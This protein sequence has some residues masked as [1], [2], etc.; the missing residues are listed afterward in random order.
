[1]KKNQ[2]REGYFTG[3][4]CLKLL[5]LGATLS[6]AEANPTIFEA[7][8]MSLSSFIVRDSGFT[9]SQQYIQIRGAAGTASTVYNGADI[10]ANIA[11]TYFD[12]SDGV[13]E[14]TL[15]LNGTEIAAWSADQI[16]EGAAVTLGN[17][18]T[19][20]IPRVALQNGDTLSLTVTRDAG[21]YGRVDSISISE[22]VEAESL[23]LSG[24]NPSTVAVASG[25]SVI[26]TGAEGTAIFS[27]TGPSGYYAIDT[28]YFDE[29]DGESVYS[30]A[31]DGVR[32]DSW[33]ANKNLGSAAPTVEAL[34]SHKTDWIYLESGSVVGLTGTRSNGEFGRVDYLEISP[35][36]SYIE[37]CQASHFLSHASMGGSRQE[38]HALAKRISEIGH[39]E[40][41]EEWID[42]QFALPRGENLLDLAL[43]HQ[44]YYAID[45]LESVNI[46]NFEYAWWDQATT[47]EEQ[48]RHRT[49]F[50]LSQIFVTSS[51][52]WGNLERH[53]IWRSY[54][55]YYDKL[56]NNAFTSHRDIL[57]DIT[58]DPFMGV[59][60]TYA[61]NSK[62][63]EE[64]D[65][66]PDENYA[67]EV[68]QLF[69]CGVYSLNQ[70]GNYQFDSNGNLIENYDNDDIREMAKVFT[71]LSLSNADGS[72]P[73]F[74]APP[75][76]R[77]GSYENEMVMVEAYHDVSEKVLLT[78]E[79]LTA[80]SSGDA[81][82]SSALDALAYHPS[83]APYLSREL[84]K[85]FTSSNPSSAYVARVSQSWRGEGQ[86]GGDGSVGNMKNVLK[87][88]LL[89]PEVREV[90]EFSGIANSANISSDNVT[91]ASSDSLSGRIKEPI[92]QWTQ[93]YRYLEPTTTAASGM[94]L[95]PPR[96][97]KAASDMTP[98]FGQVPMRA[99][100]VFNYYDT[101]HSPGSGPIAAAK[102]AFDIEFVSPET[103]TLSDHVIHDFEECLAMMEDTRT[104]SY[105]NYIQENAY[106]EFTWLQRMIEMDIPLEQFV[107]DVNRELCHGQMSKEARDVL[108]SS[109]ES[110]TANKQEQFAQALTL[111]FSSPYY[112]LSF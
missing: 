88:I 70:D 23:Q 63:D 1:M 97:K 73:N 42:A 71:G 68:M 100:S 8:S 35:S 108:V 77:S 43:Y 17:L 64:L 80:G 87:A 107:R 36:Q 109:V 26:L 25:G 61:H 111:I 52:Y 19:A 76:T 7:E 62:G 92:L 51:V 105:L 84:I 106:V 21:E 30:L 14:Y 40:A 83:T 32:V 102:S 13:S 104:T 103:Q 95:Y 60:L 20:Q 5:A 89:D 85:R 59:W 29:S 31:V 28:H 67:R 98:H 4:P 112:T 86:Y 39:L 11:V 49:A 101:E 90:I 46:H 37:V 110:S 15:N 24:Y 65:I 55:S 18:V 54:T 57:Q 94:L 3:A 38:I 99:P 16:L 53:N 69:S 96:T 78:G 50:A 34:T 12:E 47:S 44:N 48:L 9:S 41:C 58:Y 27:F 56:L 2:K 93:L 81:D 91:V 45:P 10:L 82:I 75:V 79:V 66:F 74:L 6:V 22:I 33:T 72:L